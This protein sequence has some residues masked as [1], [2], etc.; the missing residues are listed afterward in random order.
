VAALWVSVKGVGL[1]F[2][3]VNGLGYTQVLK[4]CNSAC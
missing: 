3:E 1:T 4:I 2:K